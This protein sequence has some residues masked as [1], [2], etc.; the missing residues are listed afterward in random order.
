MAYKPTDS[1]YRAWTK[2]IRPY[3]RGFSASDGYDLRKVSEWSNYRKRQIREYYEL[4]KGLSAKST[5]IYRPRNKKNLQAV[6]KATGTEDYPRLKVGIIQVPTEYDIK[7]ETPVPVKPK[8]KISKKGRVSVKV[9]GTVRDIITLEDLGYSSLDVAYEPEQFI[10][11]FLKEYGDDYNQYTIL[12]GEYEA[13]RGQG[14]PAFYKSHRLKNEFFKLLEKYDA[15]KDGCNPN[16]KNSHFYGNWFRGF[17][18]YHFENGREFSNYFEALED[19]ST[20]NKKNVEEIKALKAKIRD[21]QRDI[22][23][24]SRN[25][26]ITSKEAQKRIDKFYEKIQNTEREIKKVILRRFKH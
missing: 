9:K 8:I 6:K 26:K 11:D 20:K 3:T 1:N 16:D 19:Q 24:T 4:I 14:V 17:V 12:A 18:G 10:D 7:T 21:W 5:Y 25:R 15:D 23:K 22:R 13:G 2:A